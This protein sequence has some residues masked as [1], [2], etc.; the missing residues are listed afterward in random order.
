[1]LHT[2]LTAALVSSL[3]AALAIAAALGSGAA[4]AAP[5]VLAIGGALVG[6][7]AAGLALRGEAPTA[8]REAERQ[9]PAGGSDGSTSAARDV[10]VEAATPPALGPEPSPQGGRRTDGRVT[11]E[12]P[13]RISSAED[14]GPEPGPGDRDSPLGNRPWI[15]LV[16]ECVDLF[17]ELDRLSP[18]LDAARREMAEH[19][20]FRLREILERS[21]VRVIDGDTHFES[22]QH[23]P[24]QPTV[25]IRPGT[26]IAATVSPGFAV[27]R[28]VLR[29]ARVRLSSSTTSVGQHAVN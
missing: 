8:E 28:R 9:P 12:P 20:S 23:Q 4:S 3:V 10:A 18:R 14:A 11:L 1:M 15:K 26:P 21:E 6:A 17:D 29:R 25:S 16:E 22:G 7:A 19:V 24:E 27:D 13:T 2:Y 5:L